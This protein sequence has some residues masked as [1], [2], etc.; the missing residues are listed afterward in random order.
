MSDA[1]EYRERAVEQRKAAQA[2]NLPMVREK[3]IRAAERWDF[4]AEEIER[5]ER[6]LLNLTRA[7][8]AAYH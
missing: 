8:R 1:P 3:L 7:Q 6:G 5:C 4:L 2:C